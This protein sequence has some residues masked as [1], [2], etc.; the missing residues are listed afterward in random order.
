MLRPRETE[1]DLPDIIKPIIAAAIYNDKLLRSKPAYI[2]IGSMGNV[3]SFSASALWEYPLSKT[4]K[5]LPGS[6]IS[7][8]DVS[9]AVPIHIEKTCFFLLKN[10]QAGFPHQ[11][12]HNL[13]NNAEL[14]D[15]WSVEKSVEFYKIATPVTLEKDDLFLLHNLYA[16][17][18]LGE[19]ERFI[20][21]NYH[22]IP[23]LMEAPDPIKEICGQDIKI[24]LHFNRDEE[25]DFEALFIIIKTGLS[26]DQNLSL[27]KRI[28]DE[29]WLDVDYSI[30][31][32]L[33][34]DVESE[35]ATFR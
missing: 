15:G 23:F 26:T 17:D 11:N 32:V 9:S 20:K 31:K 18:F 4:N 13:F 16:F 10:R 12:Y 5:E 28:D 21:N 3:A 6:V 2:E 1:D 33:S 27:L 29:W 22:L 8:H 30:R 19:E 35:S 34:L 14:T 7:V 25:E 24:K